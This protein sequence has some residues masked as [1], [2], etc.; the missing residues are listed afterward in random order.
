MN[1]SVNNE[2]VNDGFE[3]NNEATSCDCGTEGCDNVS[4]EKCCDADTMSDEVSAE[5]DMSVDEQV[6]EWRDKYM[7]LQAEFDNYRKRTFKE[8]MDLIENGGSDVL[9]SMVDVH[10]DFQRAV[11][12]IGKSDDIEALRG[13]ITLV[14]NKFTEILKQKGVVEID[15][16]GK[17]FDPDFSEAIAN[18]AAGEDNKGKVVDVVQ[19]GYMLHDKVLRFAKVV[20]GE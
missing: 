20:V 12:A 6:A 4:D 18:F 7:R 17:D 11:D 9:K 14:A 16:K 5:G 15:V 10:D 8:K 19:A 3:L 13:G 1:K 2:A